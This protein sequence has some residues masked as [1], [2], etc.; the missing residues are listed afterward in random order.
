[1]NENF[2]F[3]TSMDETPKETDVAVT[4]LDHHHQRLHDL[5]LKLTSHQEEVRKKFWSLLRIPVVPGILFAG[6]IY[7]AAALGKMPKEIAYLAYTL[8]AIWAMIQSV[9]A[10]QSR[11]DALLASREAIQDIVDILEATEQT[12]GLLNQ[13]ILDSHGICRG[14][15]GY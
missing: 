15:L 9:A 13:A 2:V 12:K 4:I 1:M 5:C 6:S 11:A 14:Q 3:E 10:L 8:D 7:F